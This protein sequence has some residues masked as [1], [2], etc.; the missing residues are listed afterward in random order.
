MALEKCSNKNLNAQR[1]FT[2]AAGAR[3]NM[4]LEQ[5][6]QNYRTAQGRYGGTGS[7]PLRHPFGILISLPEER[8][9]RAGKTIR[10][11]LHILRTFLSQPDPF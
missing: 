11:I 9:S 4:R 6:I 10:E 5:V 3:P 2:P 8:N 1:G 7:C